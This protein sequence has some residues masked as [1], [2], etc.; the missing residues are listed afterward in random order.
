MQPM[1]CSTV[2]I[3]NVKRMRS[4]KGFVPFAIA[5][6]IGSIRLV[7]VIPDGKVSAKCY[8]LSKHGV[9]VLRGFFIKLLFLL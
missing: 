2:K 3:F 4:M 8:M 5:E 1:Q 7:E 6:K 9:P